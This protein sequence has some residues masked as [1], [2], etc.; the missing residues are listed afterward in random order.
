MKFDAL[1]FAG[2]GTLNFYQTGAAYALQQAGMT[3]NMSYAGT[4]AG[5]GLSVL[6]ASGIDAER[7]C[8]TAIDILKP[9]QG[10][11]VLLHPMILKEFAD[12][13]L[14]TFIDGQTLH[15]IGTRVHIS[16]TTLRPFSTN[17]KSSKTS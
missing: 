15:K 5:S 8:R 11:N 4:S 9:H 10:K 14:G 2:C 12:V 1:S 3:E 16:I 17:L 6:V 7:I 13:F